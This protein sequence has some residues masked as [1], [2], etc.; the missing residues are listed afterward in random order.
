MIKGIDEW[1]D[2]WDK[3]CGNRDDESDVDFEGEE[4]R[5]L[6]GTFGG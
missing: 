2:D 3:K 4:T 5:A 1:L 6:G